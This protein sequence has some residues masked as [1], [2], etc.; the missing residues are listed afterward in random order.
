MNFDFTDDQNSLRDAVA[1][2]VDKGFSFE[3]RHA[4]AKAGGKTREVYGE[5]AELGLGALAIPE[6]DGGMGFGPVEAM[7]VMEELGRG[8]APEPM[9]STVL[10]GANTLLLGGSEAQQQEHIPAVAAGK[11][12]ISLAYQEA[13][14]RFDVHNVETR[15]EKAGGGWKLTGEK[16]QVLD[17]HVADLLLVSARTAGG[18]RDRKGVTVFALRA[19]TPG[20]TITR[21]FRVDEIERLTGDTTSMIRVDI[22]DQLKSHIET[23][24]KQFQSQ[25]GTL[26]KLL[27][28]FEKPTAPKAGREK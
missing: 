16:I 8:L 20:V 22:W 12:L 19:D 7:V 18:P 10:L 15:A 9:L 4:I 3:R 17:G 14:S 11:R 13:R 28:A 23:A 2:W 25:A 27:S 24:E 6:A 21:Q 1:R 26:P 5:L